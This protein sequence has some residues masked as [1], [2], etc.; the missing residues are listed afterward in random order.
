MTGELADHYDL[1]LAGRYGPAR[2]R[3]RQFIDAAPQ[4]AR[5]H[6]LMGLSHHRERSYSKAVPWFE[7][8]LAAGPPYPPAAHFLGWALYHVG[9]AAKSQAAFQR[10]LQLDPEEGDTHFGLGVLALERGDIDAADAFF[11]NAITLQRSNPDRRG[12][13]AK[14]LARRSEVLEQRGD[15][16][17]AVVMLAEAVSLEPDL[18]EAL[19]R[20][21]RLL[22]RLGRDDEAAAAE[23]A[24]EEAAAR[25]ESSDGRPR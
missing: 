19:Y 21:A 5:A 4:D 2:V 15:V 8:A 16:A 23:A 9:E 11:G 14:S 7:Q 3:L 17:G 18:Y 6:F 1:I 24:A 13:V 12:G 20:Q 10:H 22:R 25:V